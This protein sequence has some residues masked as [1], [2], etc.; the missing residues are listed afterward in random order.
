MFQRTVAVLGVEGDQVR[1]GRHEV[2][3]VLVHG[4]AALADVE[5]LV[6]GVVVVPDLMA[7]ARIDGPDVVGH[8][9][10]EDAVDQQRRGLDRRRLVGLKGPG[11]REVA[12]ILRRDL[13]ERAVA[14]AGVVAVIAGP[15]VG[16]WIEQ[17]CGSR[18]CATARAAPASS[19]NNAASAASQSALHE[20]HVVETFQYRHCRMRSAQRLQVRHQVVDVVVG[21]SWG[22]ARR[23]PRPGASMV[24]LHAVRRP[25]AIRAVGVA[26]RRR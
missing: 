25:G 16:G 26:Q 9:E 21:V 12:D 23:A 14:A 7:G 5:A 8:G 22:T 17:L 24:I 10:V 6:G 18:F 20:F 1:V 15:A 4:D 2:E 19:G 3:P 13:C 11:E